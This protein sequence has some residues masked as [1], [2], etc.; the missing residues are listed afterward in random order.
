MHSEISRICFLACA[1]GCPLPPGPPP[2]RS[3]PQ[4]AWAALKAGENG[5]IPELEL[6]WIPPL[7]LRSGKFVMPCERMHPENFSPCEWAFELAVVLGL[8]EEPPQ[9]ATA[10]AH[11]SP[12]AAAR[13]RDFVIAQF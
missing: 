10:T 2:G 3:L 1:D 11:A 4:A 5:L 9:A 13:I 6:S 8:S 12:I 7:L